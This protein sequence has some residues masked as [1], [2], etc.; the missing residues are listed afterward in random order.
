MNRFFPLMLMALLAACNPSA[1]PPLEGARIGG[2]F[3]LI[4]QNGKPVTEGLLKGRY[5]I[6]YFGYT[7]C[8][9]IC[10]TDVAAL[11]QGLRTF[12]GIDKGRAAKITPV[13]ISVDPARDTPAVLR[14][15]TA[16]FDPRLIGL[17]GSPAAIASAA[18]AYGVAYSIEKPNSEGGYLVNHTGAAYL[19]DPAGKPLALLPSDQ[20]AKAVASEL[21][22]WVR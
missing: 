2:A 5:A 16:Q 22:K 10:P 18:K 15:F 11:T 20:G 21:D 3:A 8:P 12:D 14:E 1:R 19:M 13:F 6:V 9:D 17:T 4:D 7:F